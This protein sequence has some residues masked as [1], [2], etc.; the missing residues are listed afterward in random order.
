[1]VTVGQN[2]ADGLADSRPAT[3]AVVAEAAGVST[4]TVARVLHGRGY[5]ASATKERIEQALV[6]TSYRPNAVARGLRTQRSYTLG[7]LV[8]SIGGNPLFA[9]IARAVE[10][11]AVRQDY[12][13]II[14]NLEGDRERE[15]RGVQRLIE[16][17]V[18]LCRGATPAHRCPCTW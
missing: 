7:H 15:R 11:E 18:T 13:L 9:E 16:S 10:R 5:V 1:M 4:A 3:L 12:N 17:R 8:S 2:T 6:A 14:V